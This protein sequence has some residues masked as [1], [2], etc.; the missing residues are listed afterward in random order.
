MQSAYRAGFAT[1]NALIRVNNDILTSMGKNQC[2]LLVL[3]DLSA[4][5]ATVNHAK[6]LRVTQH[7]IGIGGTALI[8]FESYLRERTNTVAIRDSTAPAVELQ[9]GVP[10]GSVF[11]P[12]LFTIYPLAL[13]DIVRR[14]DLKGHLYAYDMIVSFRSTLKTHLFKLAYA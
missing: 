6:H 4:V 13:V 5:C 7:S 9:R 1:E 8:W 14:P 11:G 12:E 2:V 3:L 10:Q